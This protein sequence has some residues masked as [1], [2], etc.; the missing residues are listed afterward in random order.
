MN[1]IIKLKHKLLYSPFVSDIGE[2]IFPLDS[3]IDIVLLEANIPNSGYLY[4]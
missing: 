4:G 1:V 2:R 3:S